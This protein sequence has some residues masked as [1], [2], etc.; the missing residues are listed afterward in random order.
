MNQHNLD[1]L[2]ESM[3]RILHPVKGETAG[4]GFIIR[5]DGYLVT[6]HHVI[7]LLDALKVEYQGKEYEAQWCEELS[8]PEVDIAILKIN[9]EKAKAVKIINPQDLSTSVTVYGFPPSEK[10]FFPEG[11]NFSAQTIRPSAPV[12]ILPTYVTTNISGTNPWNKLPQPKSTFLSHRINAKVEKGTS[13]GPVFAEELNGVVGVIQC[14]K[15]DESYVIRWDNITASLDKL[16]LEPKK[17]TVCNFL[18]EIAN[19]RRF[20]FI[21]LFHTKQQI[22]LKQQYIPI[23]VTLKT[24]RKDVESFL[25]YSEAEVVDKQAYAMKSFDA[26]QETQVDWKEAKK[27]CSNQHIMVLAD[28]GM[29]KSTLLKMETITT[30]KKE[31]DKLLAPQSNLPTGVDEVIFPLFFRLSDL[32]EK[33]EEII[34][35]IP[36]LIQRDYP[37]IF[38]DIKHLLK[39]KLRNRKCLLLL[40][41]LDEV[42]KENRIRLQEKLNRFSRNYPSPM[43]CTSRIVGYGGGFIEG[44]KEVEIV[45]FAFAQTAEYIETW[46]KNAEG[47]IQDESVSAEN[48]IQQL[49]DKPQ[50]AGLA[51]NPLLLSLICSL[52]QEKDLTLPAQRTQVYQKAV[53]YML[54]KWSANRYPQSEGMITA[55]IQ[56]LEKL[57]YHFSCDDEQDGS[58]IFSLDELHRVIEGYIKSGEIS[59]DLKNYPTSRLIEELSAED[60]ILQKWDREG[61]KYIFLHRTFQEYFT[62]TYLLRKIK[63]NQNEGISLVKRLFWQYDAHETLILLAGLME[64]PLPLLQAIT[65]SK[66]DIFKTLL[67]LAGRCLAECKKDD[68]FNLAATNPLIGK[69]IEG[70]YKFWRSYPSASFIEST[71]VAL[72]KVNRQ[73]CQKLIASLKDSDSW[74]RINAAMALGNIGNSEAVNPL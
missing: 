16:G 30:A 42:P 21:T 9:I 43:I 14:S 68:N 29:G 22:E 50:I 55:K 40:D 66:D 56:L 5:D 67:L 38:P 15:S 69:I 70:I 25:G 8:N 7:Y 1:K 36:L 17:T 18:A 6:C 33:A 20:K 73:M 13:G 26:F 24:K 19:D 2:R 51:Q 63:E 54:K 31:M 74:V 48:L 39:E 72:G 34:E 23:Q 53:D 47:Y 37:L 46:F 61:D 58:E 65:Q 11:I 41:A 12:N 60:G 64:N 71:V 45:P 49:R 4:S 3:V 32:A 59:T 35:A 44:G 28:P 27:Q 62:A 57:A 10:K 52:Y